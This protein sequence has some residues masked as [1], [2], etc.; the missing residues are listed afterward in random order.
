MNLH[1]TIIFTLL[2]SANLFSS[3]DN[4][5]QMYCRVKRVIKY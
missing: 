2:I 1:Y 5:T 3:N 4:R